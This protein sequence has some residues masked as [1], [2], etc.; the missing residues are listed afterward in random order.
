MPGVKKG[1][2]GS[3]QWDPTTGQ[4]AVGTNSGTGFKCK[5]KLF[6]VLFPWEVVG[7]PLSEMPRTQLDMVLSSVSSWVGLD[8]LISPDLKLK[9]FRGTTFSRSH[10]AKRDQKIPRC[11][12]K[13]VCLVAQWTSALTVSELTTSRSSFSALKMAQL[14][15]QTP[16]LQKQAHRTPSKR[17]GEA[18]VSPSTASDG[19]WQTCRRCHLCHHACRLVA[20]GK[21]SP[22]AHSLLSCVTKNQAFDKDDRAEPAS[23]CRLVS[24]PSAARSTQLSFSLI[25]TSCPV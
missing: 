16:N 9:L 1:E 12:E 2:P 15:T 22:S 20:G 24:E 18:S 23:L 5:K 21:A 4:E 14:G 11:W 13:R 10:K 17:E 19:L 7:F 25:K 8:H 6:V 3:A